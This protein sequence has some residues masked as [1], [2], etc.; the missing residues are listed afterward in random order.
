MR[1]TV[2]ISILLCLFSF[3][4]VYGKQ[5]II[6]SLQG[7]IDSYNNWILTPT[8]D[9]FP[10]PYFSIG[11]GVRFFDEI[12]NDDFC[13]GEIGNQLWTIEDKSLF[14]YH[15]AFQPEV[16]VY[17]PSIKINEEEA[18]IF[19]SIGAGYLLPM[20]KG[21]K[22]RV[23]YYNKEANRVIFDKSELILNRKSSHKAYPFL[24]FTC[25]LNC[26]RWSLGLGYRISEFDVY[27]N[28][29]QVYVKNQKVN[30]PKENKNS[31]IYLTISY[32]LNKN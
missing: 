31:E 28:A 9:Y 7:G 19:F 30:F 18:N 8:I 32:N 5:K 2:F 6:F 12:G 3:S 26:D 14:A 27:G 29:R 15:A 22:G 17:S 4:K 11:A 25:Y 10:I 23:D 1:K 16:K 20:N 21:G 24:D 13:S